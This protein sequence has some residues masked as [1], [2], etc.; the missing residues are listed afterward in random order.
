[1]ERFFDLD[2][3]VKVVGEVNYMSDSDTTDAT[4]FTTSCFCSIAS[5]KP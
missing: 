3:Q 5:C 4:I 2:I 1:M